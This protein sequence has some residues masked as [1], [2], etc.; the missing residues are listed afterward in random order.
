[1]VDRVGEKGETLRGRIDEAAAASGPGTATTDHRTTDS[2]SLATPASGPRLV[3]PPPPPLPVELTATP[4]VRTPP[5]ANESRGKGQAVAGRDDDDDEDHR[6]HECV[7]NP[8]NSADTS[9]DE[10]AAIATASASTDAAAPHLQLSSVSLEGEREGQALTD[11]ADEEES[12]GAVDDPHDTIDDP[13]GGASDYDD[14]EVASPLN[15]PQRD[16][17]AMN[18]SDGSTTDTGGVEGHAEVLE[19]GGDNGATNS[20][21]D[22]SCRLALRTFAAEEVCQGPEHHENPPEDSPE[23]PKPPDEPARLQ[24]DPQSVQVEPG[25]ETST[26]R[27]GR[28]AHGSADEDINGEVAWA[29]QVEVERV[30]TRRGTSDEAERWSASAHERLTSGDDEHG[31]RIP[32]DVEDVPED[33][34]VPFPS[35]DQPANREDEPPSVEL[36]GE[37]I[38]YT[39]C[40]VGPTSNEADVS[41]A[42]EDVEDDGTV[43]KNLRSGSEREHERSEWMKEEIPPRTTRDGPDEPSSETAMPGD[44]HTYQEG[45]RGDTSTSCRGKGPGGQLDLQGEPRVVEVVRDRD[46]PVDRAEYDRICPSSDGNAHGVEPNPPCRDR[47]PGGR[48]G[49]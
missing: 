34:P 22:E 32:T 12:P 28:I 1:M 15:E 49:E 8:A 26:E 30:E 41:R 29:R 36:E 21:S 23:P 11:H 14:E 38:P 43:P 37:R 16:A 46:K 18:A 17:D 45:P 2:V 6:A 4:P 31:Q 39:S 48:K 27:N 47:G 20:A 24:N 40:D 7:D 9:T 25:G 10:T 5:H 19:G 44:S 33:P 13:G 3:K 35:P 42:S